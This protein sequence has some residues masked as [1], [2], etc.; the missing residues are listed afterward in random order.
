MKN[1]TDSPESWW[2]ERPEREERPSQF[3]QVSGFG[4]S[5]QWH[6]VR[7][8]SK[9]DFVWLKAFLVVGLMLALMFTI[10]VAASH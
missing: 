4:A 10:F 8:Q 5:S 2:N 6:P 1:Q 3:Q 9:R 7:A